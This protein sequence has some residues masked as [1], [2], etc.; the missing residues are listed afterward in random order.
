MLPALAVV[1]SL[2][3]VRTL[4]EGNRKIDVEIRTRTCDDRY[5]K[6]AVNLSLR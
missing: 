2:L 3:P 6:C 4:D 1:A 5:R